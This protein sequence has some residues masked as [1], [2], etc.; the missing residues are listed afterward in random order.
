M[1]RK[2]ITAT[3]L[4]LMLAVTNNLQA[5]KSSEQPKVE[6]TKKNSAEQAVLSTHK[7]LNENLVS[8]NLDELKKIYSPDY[9]LTN[10]IGQVW[11][12]EFFL[13]LLSNGSLKM[14]ELTIADEKVTIL[15]NI[16][17][18]TAQQNFKLTFGTNPMEG[19]ERTTTIYH[20]KGS[21]WVLVTQQNT[22]IVEQQS[23]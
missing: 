19:K 12:R 16:A 17:I 18:L 8:G 3:A 22:P 23:K 15:D 20:K 7:K 13:N 1:K 9:F 6:Q 11:S 10:A 2:L 14:I 21:N 5:Q 4:A